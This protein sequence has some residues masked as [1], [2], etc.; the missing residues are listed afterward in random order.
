[1]RGWSSVE[2]G[3]DSVNYPGLAAT[4]GCRSMP[5]PRNGICRRNPR[6]VR[7]VTKLWHGFVPANVEPFIVV[8]YRFQQYSDKYTMELGVLRT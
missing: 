5:G 1:V 8:F 3:V 7:E 4:S 2:I 6:V